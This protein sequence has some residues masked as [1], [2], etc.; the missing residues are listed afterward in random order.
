LRTHLSG[1]PRAKVGQWGTSTSLDSI[2]GDTRSFT[3]I[4]ALSAEYGPKLEEVASSF[5][6]KMQDLLA[7]LAL[8]ENEYE[9]CCERK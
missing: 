8:G 2:E 6:T 5:H 7:M 1:T 4:R 9:F 3:A